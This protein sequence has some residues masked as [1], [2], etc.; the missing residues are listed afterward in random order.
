MN[1]QSKIEKFIIEELIVGSKKSSLDPNESLI[2][3]G[4]LDSLALLQLIEF[5]QEEFGA[6]IEDEELLA[7]NFQSINAIMAFLKKKLNLS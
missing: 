6:K 3:T 2:S 5:L 4:V 1:M 7:E